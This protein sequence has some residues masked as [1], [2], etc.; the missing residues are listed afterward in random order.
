[1]EHVNWML[2]SVWYAVCMS[3]LDNYLHVYCSCIPC[4]LMCHGHGHGHVHTHAHARREFANADI[5]LITNRI[6]AHKFC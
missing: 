3:V 2:G 1:M 4:L 5:H 6:H